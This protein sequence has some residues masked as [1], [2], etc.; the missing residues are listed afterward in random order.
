MNK[1]I[2]I[3]RLTKDPEMKAIEESG[4]ILCKFTLAVERKYKNVNGEKEVDFI[5]IVFWGKK[6]E[7]IG[8]YMTK[9][10]MISVSGRLQTG[11]YEASDGTKKYKAEVIAEDFQ[12]V[13]SKKEVV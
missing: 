6:A 11:N 13:D 4:K 5:P 12:F 3:G 9:G 1:I 7:V 2:L 10:R 8:E